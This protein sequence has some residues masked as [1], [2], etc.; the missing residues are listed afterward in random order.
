MPNHK[1]DIVDNS[2]NSAACAATKNAIIESMTAE[3]PLD[4]QL[5]KTPPPT[6]GER[7]LGQQRPDPPA[8]TADNARPADRPG[9][10]PTRKP[11]ISSPA[12]AG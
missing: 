12:D 8:Q 11:R 9:R 3:P 4:D 7:T 5:T 2:G 6:S 10:R 1:A